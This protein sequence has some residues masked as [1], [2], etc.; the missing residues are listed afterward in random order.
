M[1]C[2]DS[3]MYPFKGNICQQN[4]RYCGIAK[5]SIYTQL[6]K[7]QRNNKIEKRGDGRRGSPCV[8]VT[9]RQA[10]TATESSDNYENLVVKHAHNPFG[11]R[12]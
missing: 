6:A 10:P 12:L 11:L 3:L 8:Y 2:L 4:K 5:I 1:L 7:L 9:I